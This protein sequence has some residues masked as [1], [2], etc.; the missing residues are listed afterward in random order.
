MK[1]EKLFLVLFVFAALFAACTNEMDEWQAQDNTLQ[2]AT[3]LRATRT[4]ISL[5]SELNTYTLN[6]SNGLEQT[7]GYGY[8][9]NQTYTNTAKVSTAHFTFSHT[10]NPSWNY[11]DGFTISNV[12]DTTQYG[13]PGLPGDSLHSKPWVTKQWGCMAVPTGA[14]TRPNFLVGYWGYYRE[15]GNITTSTT[16]TESGYSNWVKLGTGTQTYTVSNIKVTMSP[17]A[18]YGIKYGDGFARKFVAGDHFDL[19][20][21]GVKAN[22]KFVTETIP[23]PP[24][25]VRPKAITYKLADF[26]SGGSLIMSETWTDISINFAEPVKYLV[27]RLFTTDSGPYGP[28]T[29]TYFCLRDIVMQ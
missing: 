16:F 5:M 29:A 4:P 24:T 2:N 18:Y 1:K 6:S 28:N 17:W 3:E 8:Y 12:A 19:I 13:I 7:P 20:V 15:P 21:Y 25:I 23:G 14:T 9:W 27:F 11:W 22:G 10:A 26:P